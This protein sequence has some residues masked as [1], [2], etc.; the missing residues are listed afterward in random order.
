M[1]TDQRLELFFSQSLDGFFF[2][3]I[4]EPVRWDDSVDKE[5]VLDYVFEHHTKRPLPSQPRARPPRLARLLR[6][7][8]PARGNR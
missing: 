6:P 8:P 2:M 4:D 7:G 5:Q 1:N 3:M